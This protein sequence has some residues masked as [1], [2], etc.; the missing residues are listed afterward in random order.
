MVLQRLTLENFQ[1]I[2]SLDLSFPGG[3]S[4][5]IYGDNAT[6]KTT[7]FNAITWLLFD[8][9]STGAKGF[10]PKTRG[11]KGEE[12]H[13]LE[14]GVTGEFILGDGTDITFKKTF[15]ENW[16]KKRG[17]ANEELSGNTIDY[18]VNGVPVKEK[19]FN[20]RILA[21]CGGDA[22]KAKMLTMP[23]YF[24]EKM[25]WEDRRRILLDICGDVSDED[26]IASN[27]ELAELPEFLKFSD[28]NTGGTYSIDEYRKIAAAQRKD[29]NAKLDAIPGRIDEAERA[30]PDLTG[31]DADTLGEEMTAVSKEIEDLQVKKTECMTG[32]TA[33]TELHRKIAD[34]KAAI[35]EAKAAYYSRTD[36][37]NV[38]LREQIDAKQKEME[39]ISD[40][41]VADT[42]LKVNAE[43][44]LDAMRKKREQLM[45]D[46]KTASEMKWNPN[47][48]NCPMCGQRLPAEKI[49]EK[50]E[51]FNLRRSHSLEVLNTTGKKECSKDMIAD[52]E[53]KV[54]EAEARISERRAAYKAIQNEI[55]DLRNSQTEI[56]AFESTSEYRRLREELDALTASEADSEKAAENALSGIQAEI[57]AKR[58]EYSTLQE[59]SAGFA[60]K[61]A[62]EKRIAEL[63]A[64]QRELSE[65]F[66]RTEKG[67]HLADLFLKTKVSMLTDRINSKF[68]TVSFQLFT[69]QYNGGV[70]EGC[71]VLVPGPGGQMVPYAFANN[72]ARINAGLEI[73]GVLSEHWG[74]QLPAVIDNAEAVTHMVPI[75][76]QLIR[77]VVSEKDKKLRLVTE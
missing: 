13:H 75:D 71:E 32:D 73:I 55:D 25:K 39:G 46:W 30:I 58:K 2:K 65:A 3:C 19:D 11:T 63:E 51:E 18:F 27:A 45:E 69:D 54:K 35:A 28:S 61:A 16:K 52:L 31:V 72:A 4:G 34:K 23:D 57:D 26:V 56:E 12:I 76:T 1:G 43:M 14:H 5:S 74:I 7:V 64:E 40:R 77:L 21:G 38:A 15:K 17:S 29:V 22:E 36:A 44:Q 59:K 37:G 42:T 66:D 50:R 70:K 9:A 6:G 62:Q 49:N 24:P 33:V 53:A 60:V 20:D 8:K 47:S 67:L 68:K 41:I 10:T 48:E